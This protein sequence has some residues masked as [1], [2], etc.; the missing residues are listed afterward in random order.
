MLKAE[1]YRAMYH[2]NGWDQD[3]RGLISSTM[4]NVLLT[5]RNLPGSTSLMVRNPDDLLLG[6][7]LQYSNAASWRDG[8]RT[9]EN[10]MRGTFDAKC[11]L[12]SAGL[13]FAPCQSAIS[14]YAIPSVAILNG[15]Q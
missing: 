10:A 6:R 9:D 14:L 13:I 2:N 15:T 7:T 1:R 12:F 3:K 11:E 5:Q 4:G 8:R